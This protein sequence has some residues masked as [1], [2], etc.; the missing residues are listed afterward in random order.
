MQLQLLSLGFSS[1]QCCSGVTPASKELSCKGKKGTSEE[2]GD[3]FKSY[4]G[5]QPSGFFLPDLVVLANK[6]E[7]YE[8]L[9]C[10]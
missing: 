3:S 2:S 1:F 5:D 4:F 7:Q 9:K 8:G 10:L 6:R